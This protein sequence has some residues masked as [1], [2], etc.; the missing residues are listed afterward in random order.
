MSTG[1][2]LL[3]N[4]PTGNRALVTTKE[5]D[6][7]TMECTPKP[8]SCDGDRKNASHVGASRDEEPAATPLALSVGGISSKYNVF[9]ITHCS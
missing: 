4:L 1:V 3:L 8:V 2:S 7:P 5:Q 6:T 9:Q